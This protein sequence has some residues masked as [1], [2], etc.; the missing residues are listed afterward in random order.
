MSFRRKGLNGVKDNEVTSEGNG[1]LVLK[2]DRI[3]KPLPCLKEGRD[4]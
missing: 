3:N 2:N 4:L 1:D